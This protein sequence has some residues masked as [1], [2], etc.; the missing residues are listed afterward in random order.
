[1]DCAIGRESKQAITRSPRSAACEDYVTGWR[2]PA[3]P[4]G[5]RLWVL[6]GVIWADD[7]PGTALGALVKGFLSEAP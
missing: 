2:H 7:I 6:R 3:V 1:M 4:L 5:R